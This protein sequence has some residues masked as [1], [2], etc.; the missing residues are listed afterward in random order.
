[1][2]WRLREYAPAPC[3]RHFRG[4]L[5]RGRV[6]PGDGAAII[7]RAKGEPTD[8]L[9]QLRAF[10]RMSILSKQGKALHETGLCPFAVACLPMQPRRS[11]DGDVRHRYAR[12]R[13][14]VPAAP[15]RNGPPPP[16]VVQPAPAGRPIFREQSGS[17]LHNR[18]N[19]RACGARAHNDGWRLRS[20]RQREPNHRLR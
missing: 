8:F 13:P 7:A 16:C 17:H 4:L 14:L 9:K 15:P 12:P 6:P 18:G 2:P 3:R 10:M 5:L 1:M 20:H 11:C 19:R